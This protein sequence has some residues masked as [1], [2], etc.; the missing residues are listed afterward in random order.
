MF[1]VCMDSVHIFQQFCV[2]LFL[3]AYVEGEAEKE[4]GCNHLLDVYEKRSV[5]FSIS[6]ASF[7]VVLY[8]LSIFV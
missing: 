5:Y 7:W 3:F 6:L 1:C 8:K 2:F 4:N